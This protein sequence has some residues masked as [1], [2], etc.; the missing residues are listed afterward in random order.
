MC[1]T[2]FANTWDYH[3]PQYR[4]ALEISRNI[5]SC[6]LHR[7]NLQHPWPWSNI[8]YTA[9]EP[10]NEIPCLERPKQETSFKTNQSHLLHPL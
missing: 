10:P 1:A 2:W 9:K 5:L 8:P 3:P 7:F 4:V 6:R